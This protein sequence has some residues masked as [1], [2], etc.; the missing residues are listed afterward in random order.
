MFRHACS[1]AVVTV[2]LGTA[3]VV[4]S[5]AGTVPRVTSEV[6]Q[7]IAEEGRA[8]VVVAFGV[9]GSRE[10]IA[11]ARTASERAA[12]RATSL[13]ILGCLAPGE[14]EVTEVLEGLGA[15]AGS[16]SEA[17]L[18][19]LFE[20]PAVYAV[21]LDR[22]LYPALAESVPLVR[23]AALHA[24]GLTG[25]GSKVAVADGGVDTDH[26]D[27]AGDLV[28][29][30]CFCSTEPV[31]CCPDGTSRQTGPGSAEDDDGHGTAVAGIVGSDGL[32]AP[33]GGA[34]SA[35]VVAVKL[36]GRATGGVLASDVLAAGD[37]IRRGHPD[38]DAINLSFGS[39]EA[40]QAPCDEY[41]GTTAVG[42]ILVRALREQG[43]LVVVSAMNDGRPDGL[44]LPACLSGV[45]AVGATYDD[46][47]RL[48]QMTDFSNRDAAIALL[49]PGHSID[50]S[51]L[52]GGVTTFGGTSASAPLVAACAAVLR[53]A[54]PD[55]T[56]DQLR[57]ALTT[58]P[59]V[60]TDGVTGRRWP[61]LDC[62][63]ALVALPEPGPAV[64]LPAAA[65]VLLLIRH[66]RR[67]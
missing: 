11:L 26:P 48:D 28:D 49:A 32:A 31:P 1:L 38:T 15:L 61:R 59:T 25:T 22:E 57:A 46:G 18:A 7:R 67:A 4:A 50:T 53:E 3:L 20:D 14:F 34:P 66:G 42:A 43:I 37:W 65:L 23:L 45:I 39:P 56:A 19:H 21:G 58:S 13:R 51:A 24:T 17:G 44:G 47:P 62:E 29:Q 55:A 64:L 27:L 9:P 6:R 35:S 16:V 41:D 63:A 5:S 30:A 60:V 2:A 12:V 36:S 54:K 52:G 33:A 8:R 10:P 40:L